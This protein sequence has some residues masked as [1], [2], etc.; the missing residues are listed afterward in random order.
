MPLGTPT[1]TATTNPAGYVELSVSCSGA[2][3]VTIQR[4]SASG[5]HPVRGAVDAD[6]TSGAVIAADWEIPQ[7]STYTYVATVTGDGTTVSSDP[8]ETEGI[9]RGGDYIA[10][11]GAPFSGTLINVESL[12][13]EERAAQQD[14]V[15]V[16]GRHDPVVVTFGRTWMRGDLVLISLT[17]EERNALENIF[18]D[19]RLVLFQ[20]RIGVGYDEP[21]FLAAANVTVERVSTNAYEPARRWNIEVQRI[22]APPATFSIPVGTTWQQRVASGATWSYWSSA[23]TWLDLAGVG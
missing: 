12:T 6:I 16:L 7:A 1:L 22:E 15:T 9:D 3:T 8:V 21:L 20:P 4:T 19:G 10:A 5:S 14:V 23:G 2:T 18:A 13:Q 17:D 11:L